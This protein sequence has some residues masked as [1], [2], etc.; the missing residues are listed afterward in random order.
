[1]SKRHHAQP[2]QLSLWGVY[3]LEAQAVAA[4]SRPAPEPTPVNVPVAEV[5]PIFKAAPTVIVFR[6]PG[7]TK[8]SRLFCPLAWARARTGQAAS[9]A[10]SARPKNRR[11]VSA[12]I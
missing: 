12:A 2:G 10:P 3:E 7:T 8:R 4:C 11:R 6:S 9:G 5:L 1:M